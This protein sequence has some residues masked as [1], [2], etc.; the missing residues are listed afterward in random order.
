MKKLTAALYGICLYCSA[1]AQYYDDNDYDFLWSAGG[2]YYS[3]FLSQAATVHVQ[4]RLNFYEF[5]TRASL[6][7]DVRLAA[8]YFEEPQLI[9][10]DY[11]LLFETPIMLNFNVMNG[12]TRVYDKGFGYYGGLGWNN[13]WALYEY[14]AFGPMANAGIR[15]DVAKKSPIDLGMMFMVDVSGNY[16][17]VFGISISYLFGM[18]K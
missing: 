18:L 3:S 7:L 9:A 8:G 17:S 1:T 5:S 14:F 11:Y 2:G 6:S 13:E 4:P 16:N 12:A 10:S 15:F